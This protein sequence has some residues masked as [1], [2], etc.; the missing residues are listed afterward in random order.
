L[1]DDLFQ[2]KK[3][4]II[5]TDIFFTFD[6]QYLE[7]Y[8]SDEISEDELLN[9]TGYK[10]NWGYPWD[11]YM[12]IFKSLKIMG[13]KCFSLD[14]IPRNNYKFLKRRDA[15]LGWK[16]ANIIKNYPDYI[17][18]FFTGE[19]RLA[20]Q[21]IL[22][23][24]NRE[25]NQHDFIP[26]RIFQNLD[27]TY[28]IYEGNL[29]KFYLLDHHTFSVISASKTEKYRSFKMI[30]KK[31]DENIE[32]DERLDLQNT[33][34]NLIDSFLKFLKIDPYNYHIYSS[35]ELSPF[36]IDNYPL[37]VKAEQKISS[38][39]IGSL[40]D[41]MENK[42]YISSFDLIHGGEEIAH[43][44]NSALKGELYRTPILINVFDQF[45]LKTIEEALGFLGSKILAP[46]RS[47]NSLVNIGKYDFNAIHPIISNFNYKDADIKNAVIFLKEHHFFEKAV[48]KYDS[49]PRIIEDHITKESKLTPL[50]FHDLG[51]RLGEKLY[52]DYK[53]KR[54]TKRYIKRLFMKDF[55]DVGSSFETYIKL[56]N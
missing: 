28:K 6:Q 38:Q 53:R 2:K 48:E 17:F 49:I 25:L 14:T 21:H 24:I 43:F 4:I 31:W 32:D 16:I 8:F 51:Y 45:Y 35:N 7:K 52:E 23:E 13:V 30:K 20:T 55:P 47:F 10:K 56:I 27:I 36:L 12:L 19:A 33:I 9:L 41:P 44:V 37:V 42:I 5:A 40:F 46:E 22:Y 11:N 50:L 29:E 34:F 39:N 18:I 1:I 3:Q 26:L 54:I 15:N